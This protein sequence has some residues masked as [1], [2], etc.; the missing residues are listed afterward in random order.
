M[1]IR[2]GYDIQFYVPAPLSYVAQLHVHPSRVADLREPDVVHL[3]GD[4]AS[5]NYSDSFGNICTRFVAPAG[6]PANLEFD[7]DRGLRPSRPGRLRR[8]R[9][10]DPGAARRRARFLLAAATARSICSRPSPPTSSAICRRAGPRPRRRRMGQSQG[11][12][13]LSVRPR[14]QDRARCLHRTRSASAATSSISP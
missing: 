12:L 10:P 11:H 4:I 2:L 6:Q 3:D 13:R 14:H 7:A 1:F 9:S 5:H 8:P